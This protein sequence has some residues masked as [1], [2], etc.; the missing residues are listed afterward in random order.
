M[1]S[2]RRWCYMGRVLILNIFSPLRNPNDDGKIRFLLVARMLWI[3][4][5]GGVEAAR[6]IKAKCP[7]TEFQLLGACG[8]INPSKYWSRA[9]Q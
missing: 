8:V 3:R 1:K 5:L 6:H 9:D 7:N 2:I 4:A